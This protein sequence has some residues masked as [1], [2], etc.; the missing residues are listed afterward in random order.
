MH[1]AQPPSTDLDIWLAKKYNG[2]ASV[3][4]L[5]YETNAFIDFSDRSGLRGSSSGVPGRLGDIRGVG[6]D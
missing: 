4:L 6:G 3:A 1:F 2:C 5:G